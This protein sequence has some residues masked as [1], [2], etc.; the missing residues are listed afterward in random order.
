MGISSDSTVVGV[1]VAIYYLGCSV[2]AVLASWYAD[3][4]GRKKSIFACLA[5][6]TL[7]NLFMFTSGLGFHKGALVM[8]M[9]GRVVMGLGVGGIDAV[10]P[11]YSSELSE[12]DARGKALA[13][14]FQ[15]N[16]FGLNMAFGIN[17]GVTV[18]LGKDSQVFP[19]L[20]MALIEL[21]PESP[22]FLVMH[23]RTDDAKASLKRIYGR[24]DDDA[25]QKER[26]EELQKAHENE[27]ASRIAYTDMFSPVHQQFH[28]TMVVVMGQVNQALTGY[29]AVSVY[30]P[31]IFELL[32]YA[33][34]V[35]EYLTQANY[36]SYLLFMTLAWLLIDA[37][38]RRALMLVNSAGLTGSFVLLCVFGG[39]A[40]RAD[41]LG[42]P[43]Q[44]VA[45]PGVVTLFVATVNFGV[46]WLATVWLVPTEIF[47]TSCRSKGAAVS[48]VI[49]GVMNFAVTL[50]TPI[51][52]NGAKYWLFLVFA[53]TNLF[54]GLWTFLYLPETGNRSF[55]ENQKFFEEAKEAGT[56]RVSKVARGE[57]RKL[58]NIE[59]EATGETQP[60]LRRVQDQI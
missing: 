54:A 59:D 38:G 39:L 18:G 12:S 9:V 58:P 49:W 56:W 28:P 25:K 2:G 6:T 14:E 31:Q 16:I 10:V 47:P 22:R 32:G 55:E 35:A 43:R 42:I 57:Y 44:A 23:D 7:G 36:L 52:F 45:I 17:L 20:L 21:L 33:V 24:T 60:L 50:V 15:M 8:M 5:I 40:S 37:V 19:V 53:A 4:Y 11:T 3:K 1:I 51:L 34:R 48:V 27:G 26:L 13:Q 41:Q 46:G 29:G 30:G